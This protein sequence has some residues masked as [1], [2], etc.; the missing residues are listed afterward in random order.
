LYVVGSHGKLRPVYWPRQ[1][2]FW[3]SARHS[4]PCL[5]VHLYS[6]WELFTIGTPRMSNALEKE[7]DATQSRD[8]QAG[9]RDSAMSICEG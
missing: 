4:T 7:Y 6:H 3:V 5:K 8:K 1:S 9:Q 2:S